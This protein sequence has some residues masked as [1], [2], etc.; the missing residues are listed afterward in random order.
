MKAIAGP[1]L[2]E[3]CEV[4]AR[5]GADPLLVQ[6]PGGNTSFKSGDQLWVKASGVWLAEANVRPIF[7]GLSLAKARRLA[8]DGH[9]ADF[10]P[11]CLPGSQ[12]SHRPSIETAFHALMPH[13]AVVHAHAVGSMT[14]SILEEGPALAATALIGLDWAWVPYHRPGAPLAAAVENILSRR[15]VDV[16]ILQNHG[17]II[18]AETPKRAEVLLREVESRLDFPVRSPPQIDSTPLAILQTDRYEPIP[19]VS[20]LAHVPELFEAVT[21]AA[22]F[23]DQVVFL[24]GAVP[25]STSGETID[26]AADRTRAESG[27]APA[28]VLSQGIGA[29]G[30]RNRTPA[31]SAVIHGLF[32]VVRRLPV[33][34]RIRGLPREA[35]SAL[36]NWEA[37]SYRV[38]LAGSGEH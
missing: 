17:V 37:E 2:A 34:A 31:A 38:N 27:I 19:S 25:A 8:A 7:A 18:G 26:E 4:S 13:R 11:A 29:F 9:T 33:G 1:E 23:P 15:R 10:T 5:I 30:A 6:G 12:P 14:I 36:L 3:L 16:L 24:G 32:E 22:L 20:P 35:V 21:T 28:L